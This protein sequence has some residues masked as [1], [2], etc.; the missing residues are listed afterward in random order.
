M[1]VPGT[2]HPVLLIR[3]AGA[4]D[5][6]AVAIAARGHPVVQDPYLVV[7]PSADP[8]AP[9]TVERTLARL[10]EE[11]DV[12]AVTSVNAI[13]ALE[14][15]SSPAD[16]RAAVADGRRRGLLAAA[17]GPAT[18][19]ALRD[20][21]F[22]SVLSPEPAT[23][24]ALLELLLARC[25]TPQQAV[26]PQGSRAMRLLGDGLE[27]AGWR[28]D[29]PVVYTTTPVTDRPS[30]VERLRAG[31]IGAVVVR[32]PTAVRALASH[33]PHLPATTVLVCGGPTTAAEARAQL[34]ARIVVSDGPTP[35]AIAAA[36]D[37]AIA[38]EER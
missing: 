25:R 18:A 26:L 8:G 11:A 29:R 13:A 38:L 2:S 4:P 3:P 10:R 34:D 24:D 21:G 20:L 35:E 1:S 6:D 16:V 30:S 32:S 17:V 36:V 31:A 5:R 23:G 7:A 15:L 27:A 28:V 33:V 12:L 9:G 14:A 37:E 19:A 22:G